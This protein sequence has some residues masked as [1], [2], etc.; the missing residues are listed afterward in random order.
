MGRGEWA[1]ASIFI[2]CA[3]LLGSS[4]SS[5]HKTEVAVRITAVKA[6]AEGHA[7]LIATPLTAGAAAK[8]AGTSMPEPVR[9]ETTIPG[10]V[11]LG[12]D[13]R[14]SWRVELAAE[15]WWAAPITIEP[16]AGTTIGLAAFPTSRVAGRVAMPE[17]APPVDPPATL[18]ARF[19]PAPES[20][21]GTKH[22]GPEGTVVCPV[23]D[24]RIACPLPA[25]RF[26]LRFAAPGSVPIYRWDVDLSPGKTFAAGV[27]TLRQGASVSGQVSPP[28]NVGPA[29]KATRVELVP[30]STRY[31]AKEALATRLARRAL[32]AEAD[33]RG[34]FQLAGVPPGRYHLRVERQGFAPA[35]V[36][37][38]T[39][40]AGEETRLETPIEL[41]P[42]HDLE[43]AITPPLDV[44]GRPWTVMLQPL[45]RV[46]S[47]ETGGP[48]ER[49]EAD[50]AGW[51]RRAALTP[52]DYDLS[53]WDAD[54]ASWYDQTIT[55]RPGDGRVVVD[56]PV[57]AIEGQV[58]IGDE[59]LATELVFGGSRPVR[60]SM[61]A[62]EEGHFAGYLPH[63]G[64][65]EVDLLNPAFGVG[66]VQI[67][68]V[69]IDKPP[70]GQAAQVTIE[71]PDTRLRCEVVDARG[72]RAV[73]A[74]VHFY[75]HAEGRLERR[76][77][78]RTD[79][80][81]E[82]Q[83]RGF[84]PGPIS[85]HAEGT[86]GTSSDLSSLSVSARGERE[87]RLTLRR[88][89][90]IRGRVTA[91]GQPVLGATV[92]LTSAA[93][94]SL[95]P[96]GARVVTNHLGAFIFR[97]RPGR[98][99]DVLVTEPTHATSIRR[100]AVGEEPADLAFELVPTGGDLFVGMASLANGMMEQTSGYATVHHRGGT[101]AL[102]T[103]LRFGDFD[104]E[105]TGAMGLLVPGLEP[106]MYQLC[107]HAAGAAP[108]CQEGW[109][110]AGGTLAFELKNLEKN[111]ARKGT[112]R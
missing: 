20:G 67:E 95:P 62:D 16:R 106:G 3:F 33:E 6:R 51:W 47:N 101:V 42:P 83:F 21:K 15:A 43:V 55:V 90:E 96:S 19:T 41:V 110:V 79:A 7:S 23:A 40:R 69:E 2:L 76:S 13:T 32:E 103:L 109:L 61:S 27:L 25:A 98:T 97:D 89:V 78:L 56:I 24:G 38:V 81:G 65:W 99:Y 111:K 31:L 77:S 4:H 70:G 46:A 100:V 74:G 39:V 88:Q 58:R 71:L 94:D 102:T 28:A 18:E 68:P 35:V 11:R 50:L 30:R 52:G 5:P 36:N 44:L 54:G 34:F 80:E 8:V 66:R 73:G 45:L 84:A 91:A 9:L 37:P 29:R 10:T 85:V 86:D 93:T 60:V 87:V 57:V 49:G 108:R 104:V 1:Q 72:K 64:R 53:V 26:D 75:T 17:G 105:A 63:E 48:P 14:F 12:L 22:D 107:Q 112:R 59:P 82:A 92:L